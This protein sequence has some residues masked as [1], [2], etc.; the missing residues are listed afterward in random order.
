MRILLLLSIITFSASLN[1]M[2]KENSAITTYQERCQIIKRTLKTEKAEFFEM[3]YNKHLD[4][5]QELARI[6]RKFTF[7][8]EKLEKEK[9]ASL[10]QLKTF[11]NI[12]DDDWQWCMKITNNMCSSI[13]NGINDNLP[14]A[15]HDP[16]IYDKNK[17]E[18]AA[19]LQKYGLNSQK[20]NIKKGNKPNDRVTISL[21]TVINSTHYPIGVSITPPEI[22]FCEKKSKLPNGQLAIS[23]WQ[24]ANVNCVEPGL[25]Y[26]ITKK[27]NKCCSI[28]TLRKSNEYILF[29]E[30]QEK[31][32]EIIPSLD[33]YKICKSITKERSNFYRAEVKNRDEHFQQLCAIKHLWKKR[34]IL[35]KLLQT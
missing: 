19:Q 1:G 27:S 2:E 21:T 18:F 8:E 5:A 10:L 9:E 22:E 3:I 29:T 24:F 20:I 33:S 17:I 11:H 16:L 23:A 4:P 25:L 12:S 31:H 32:S 7:Y 13:K 6:E 26:A 30:L 28:K 15:F 14:D 35:E 34:K